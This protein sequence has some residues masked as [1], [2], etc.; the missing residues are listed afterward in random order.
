MGRHWLFV[1]LLGRCVSQFFC[2]PSL[3]RCTLAS[4]LV[5]VVGIEETCLYDFLVGDYIRSVTYEHFQFGRNIA[6]RGRD[7]T[8]KAWPVLVLRRSLPLVAPRP[9][10]ILIPWSPKMVTPRRET[11]T[12]RAMSVPAE[13]SPSSRFQPGCRN[14]YDIHPRPS[15]SV[16]QASRN[17]FACSRSLLYVLVDLHLRSSDLMLEVLMKLV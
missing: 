15:V 1:V 9:Y 11:R 3:V 13:P 8:D 7:S 10:G 6:Q 4:P 5:L 12:S 16:V 2:G 14:T 17:P